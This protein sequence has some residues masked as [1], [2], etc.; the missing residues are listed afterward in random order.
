MAPPKS[1][2]APGR[3]ARL[4]YRRMVAGRWEARRCAGDFEAANAAW[5]QFTKSKPNDR[6]TWRHGTRVIQ[7]QPWSDRFAT[8]A[9]ATGPRGVVP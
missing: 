5:L 8:K 9:A 3:R 4:K 7:E 2:P 6:L 1:K